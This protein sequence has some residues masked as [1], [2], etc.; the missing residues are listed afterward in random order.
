M[1]H[2]LQHVALSRK[3]AAQIAMGLGL[4]PDIPQ[5]SGKLQGLLIAPQRLI[6]LALPLLIPT[7]ADH[8]ARLGLHITRMLRQLKL[9]P[10]ELDRLIV[11]F[12]IPDGIG[13]ALQLGNA[14]TQSN[15]II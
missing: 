15:G 6:I 2:R 5:C 12:E 1:A 10:G 11:P 8:Q 9:L 13:P 3:Q 7:Q 14:S 4:P